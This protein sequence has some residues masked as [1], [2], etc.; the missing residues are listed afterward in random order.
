MLDRAKMKYAGTELAGDRTK[1]SIYSSMFVKL[2]IF[3]FENIAKMTAE[4][5]LKLEEVGFGD[6]PVAVFLGIP[7]YDS[8]PHFLATAFI[9]QL[10][11]VLEKKATRYKTGKCK[12]KVRFILDEF[13]NLPAIQG[14]DKFITVCLGRNIAYDLYIQ[15]YSQVEQLYGKAMDTIVGNCGNQIYILTNDDRTAEN[16]SKNLGN[17]TIIDIQRSGERLSSSKSVME[18]ATEKPLLNMNELEELREGECVVKRVMKRRD[19]KGKRIRPTPIFNSEASGKRFLYRY[20]YLTDTFPNPGEIDL[21][22]VNTE[23]RSWI[24]HRERVWNFKRSFVQMQMERLNA[25]KVLKLKELYN[26]DIILSLLEKVLTTEE[27][28]K[29]D[30]E[31]PV[32]KLLDLIQQANLKEEEKEQIIS[33]IELSA[34]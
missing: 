8:S 7:D 22:E 12:R 11:F 9:R 33:M 32:M 6:K 17:E 25:N 19:L 4:S 13:G 28:M 23:D 30:P 34:T 10:T 31:L 16:F 27:L 2:A 18:S 29:V 14:M 1:G 26:K 3:T 24:D 20:E 5:S 21:T 15:A